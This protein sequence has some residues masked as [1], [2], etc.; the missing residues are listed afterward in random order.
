MEKNF[1]DNFQEIVFG[2]TDPVISQKISRAVKTGHLRKIAAR[3]YTTNI[4][5]SPENIIKKYRYYILSNLYPKAVISHR[6]ALEG[7][8][9]AGGE[10]TLS[11]KYTRTI[12]LP[13]LIIHLVKGPGADEEDTPF[14]ENLYIASQGR[15][16]LENMQQSRARKHRPKTLSLT[17]I[18][19]RLDR[20]IRIFGQE[21]V[22]RLRD[23]A[24]RVASRLNMSKEF[25][26]LDKLIGALLGTQSETSL[27]TDAGKSRALGIPY[28]LERI[29]LFAVLAT[30]LLQT[31]L[32]S[33][34]TNVK[35]KPAMINQAFFDAYFSNYIEG[36]RFA[37]E[38]AEK[39]IFENKIFKNRFEDSHDILGTYQMVSDERLMQTCPKSS[40]Q[41]LLLLKERH[42]KLMQSRENTLP[43]NFKNVVNRAGNTV[44]VK[45]EEVEGSLIKGFEFYQKLSP[46]I[47]RA[48]FIMF[49]I[50]EVHPFI[51]GNGRISRIFMNVELEACGLNRIIIPTVY[52][53][54]YLLALRKLSRR[55]DADPYTRMLLTAQTFTNSI[56]FDSYEQA[57]IQL[58]LRNAFMEPSEG[59]LI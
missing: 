28:D 48:I 52:R 5:D 31:K 39:I 1:D 46:G 11:Y 44:F 45:P 19:S 24:K 10:V 41:F 14:L 54:D 22:N 23:Q 26:S 2:S 50:S 3:L 56:S 47:S 58:K 13:S 42:G 20:F 59:K 33:I 6:S 38:E 36:T 25:S 16:F 43:G 57:L 49:L 7:G 34:P 55:L 35:T 8:I 53:E 29:E 37:I 51:D 18:E 40:E 17:E 9:S 27:Q 12:S 4:K 30:H 21:E 32:P 15:A